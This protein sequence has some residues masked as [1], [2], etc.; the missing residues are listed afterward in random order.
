MAETKEKDSLI[1][2]EYGEY[3]ERI[4]I[5]R[6]KMSQAELL[7][8]DYLL[9]HEEEFSHRS[10]HQLAGEIGVSVATII[11]FCK[12]MGYTGFA[13][14]KFHIQ[15]GRVSA[16]QSEIHISNVVLGNR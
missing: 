4:R 7:V 2:E 9:A 6:G 15:Q 11:R 16:K 13:D 1:F 12:T 5:N 8:A 10:I 14:L 3:M